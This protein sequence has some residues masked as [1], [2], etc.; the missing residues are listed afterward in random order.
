MMDINFGV[1]LRQYL[2]QQHTN[3]TYGEIRTKILEQATRYLPYI[4][5][6]KVDFLQVGHSPDDFPHDIRIKIYFKVT[7]LQISSMLGIDVNNN[8]N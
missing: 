8:V 1:G 7:A 4:K 5:I 3:K 2:F 6:E